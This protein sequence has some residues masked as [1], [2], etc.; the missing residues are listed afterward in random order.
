[1]YQTLIP[2]YKRT[3]FFLFSTL[4][5]VELLLIQWV[6]YQ[7]A[8]NAMLMAVTMSAV[9]S[10]NTKK[11][12]DAGLRLDSTGKKSGLCKEHYKEWKKATKDDRSLER[13]RYD[14]D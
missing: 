12:E 13:A 9:R 4:L 7:K 14:R 5:T 1:M 10:L 8:Q 3:K 6:L 11:I 2:I